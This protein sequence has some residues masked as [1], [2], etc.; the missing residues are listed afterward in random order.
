MNG[1]FCPSRSHTPGEHPDADTWAARLNGD[2]VCSFCGSLHPEDA[3]AVMCEFADT[4]E[5]RFC[6]SDDARKFYLNRTG[7]RSADD[8]GIKFHT[9]HLPRASTPAMNEFHRQF[10]RCAQRVVAQDAK[11]FVEEA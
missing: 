3:V 2:R 9:W 11:R 4:G 1:F 8:G 7:V 10:D 5:G 6:T